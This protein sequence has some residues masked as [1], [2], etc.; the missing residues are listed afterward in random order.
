MAN[1]LGLMRQ[2]WPTISIVFGLLAGLADWLDQRDVITI[3]TC[4]H[5]II[6]QDTKPFWNI[7]GLVLGK[8]KCSQLKILFIVLMLWKATQLLHLTTRIH[9]TVVDILNMEK[10]EKNAE[11]MSTYL[12]KFRSASKIHPT[13]SFNNICEVLT[14]VCKL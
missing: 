5:E 4:W 6:W 3:Q 1:E 7:F 13:I 10:R 9:Y 8:R 2:L 11:K 14:F 12:N